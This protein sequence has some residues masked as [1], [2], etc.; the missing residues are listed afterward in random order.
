MNSIKSLLL[1][2]CGLAMTSC[3][4]DKQIIMEFVR[5]NSDYPVTCEYI[6]KTKELRM[7]DKYQMIYDFY[8]QRSIEKKDMM[9][10]LNAY[11]EIIDKK[12]EL[13]QDDDFLA[14]RDE[15]AFDVETI[16]YE[17]KR[18]SAFAKWALNRKSFTHPIDIW[19]S[20]YKVKFRTRDEELKD[21]LFFDIDTDGNIIGISNEP[22]NTELRMLDDDANMYL[23]RFDSIYAE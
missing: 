5:G 14:H 2:G 23:A 21:T 10:S 7:L 18:D 15:L 19:C 3:E 12:P 11:L 1:L 9:D 16:Q 20:R 22:N 8:N 6:S 17:Y 4:T 13:V